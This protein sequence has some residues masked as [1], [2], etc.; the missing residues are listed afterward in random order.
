MPLA[1]MLRERGHRNRIEFFL[2]I[3]FPPTEMLTTLPNHERLIGNMVHYDAQESLGS[4]S[5]V[6]AC[7][8][9][10][11][12]GSMRLLGLWHPTREYDFRPVP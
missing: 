3:P 8:M 6:R 9:A 1:R 11:P 2:H 7:F 5:R 4:Q 12:H 10:P